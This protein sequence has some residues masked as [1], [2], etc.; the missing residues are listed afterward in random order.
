MK[1]S[2]MLMTGVA[3]MAVSF[4]PC[5]NAFKVGL[6]MP[7]QNEDRWYKEGFML[8]KKLKKEGFETELFYGGDVDIELQ[9]KQILRAANDGCNVLIIGSIDGSAI[10]DPL[11]DAKKKGIAIISY[12]RLITGTDAV[13]Y[14]ATFDNEM[15]GH[16]QGKYL[17]DKLQLDSSYESRNIE[18]FYGSLNDNNAKFFWK[19]ALEELQPYID[20]G[21]VNIKSGVIT[22][23]AA[24]TPDWS[25]TE[26]N[27]RMTK[28]IEENG[29]GP[30]GTK[31]DGVL[32]PADCIAKGVIFAL[33]K[34]GYNSS[35][36]PIITGQDATAEGLEQIKAGELAMTIL[37]S[38]NALS[39]TVVNMVKSISKHEEVEIN[40]TST[41]NNGAKI[42]DSYLCMPELVDKTNIDK[43]LNM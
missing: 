30:N 2:S 15:V 4:S 41:Y 5:A 43:V 36:M 3:L 14:Y 24:Q 23:E 37:K 22:P 10:S 17:V 28:L 19:G 18:L 13:N 33:K 32:C 11:N 8:E 39:D 27:K 7:T 20:S 38:P 26:A 34:A 9:K 12:D 21:V 1:L 16:I 31:L 25:D 29:Y 42:V 6:L 35:N 40:D